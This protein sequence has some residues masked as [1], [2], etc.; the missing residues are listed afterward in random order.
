LERMIEHMERALIRVGFLDADHPKGIMRVL[1]RL[2]GRSQLEPNGSPFKKSRKTLKQKDP[3][4]E[5]S[6]KGAD[7]FI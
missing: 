5:S 6:V 4:L 3:L 7:G 2:F 1:R